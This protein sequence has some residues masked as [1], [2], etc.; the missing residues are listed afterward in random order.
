MKIIYMYIP[1]VLNLNLQGLR[2]AWD[3]ATLKHLLQ[4]SGLNVCTSSKH[5]NKTTVFKI[6]ILLAKD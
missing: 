3:V 4:Y 2:E 5:A 6:I 1:L